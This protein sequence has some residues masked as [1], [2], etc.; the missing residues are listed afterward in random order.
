MFPQF[1]AS[2]PEHVDR[3][4]LLEGNTPKTVLLI[5][6]NGR[7]SAA[8][9]AMWRTSVLFTGTIDNRTA[10]SPFSTPHISISTGLISIK[11]TYFILSIYMTLRTK[12]E[13]N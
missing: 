10:N 4:V 6:T 2:L 8:K 1:A 9:K 12:F 7:V 3:M 11:F 5:K 13:R